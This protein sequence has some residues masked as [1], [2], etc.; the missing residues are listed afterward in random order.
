MVCFVF[1]SG[2]R[3]LNYGRLCNSETLSELIKIV[4]LFGLHKGTPP[5]TAPT[6]TVQGPAFCGLSNVVF[7]LSL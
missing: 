3:L 1:Q 7:G 4:S 6:V 5:P 2:E